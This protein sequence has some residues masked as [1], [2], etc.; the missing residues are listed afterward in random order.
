MI[1]QLSRNY[2]GPFGA[3][4]I[5][6]VDTEIFQKKYF[7]YCMECTFCDDA[8]CAYGVD[9]DILNVKRLEAKQ[10]ELEQ[11]T[12]VPRAEWFDGEMRADQEFPGGAHTRTAVRDGRCVFIDKS[13]RG[14]MIHSYCLEK[15]IDFHEL[16]PIVS[17]LFPVTFDDELLHAS[18]EIDDGTL[19]CAG[20]GPSLYQ[21]LRSDLQYYFGEEFVAELD[22]MNSDS[23]L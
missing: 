3:P 5:S 15:G 4:T 12:G 2:T 7:T 21:G 19:V 10:T 6:S 18:S 22:A 1:R 23:R 8:C 20:E 9:V 17:V 11:W 14:C 13:G 16:K